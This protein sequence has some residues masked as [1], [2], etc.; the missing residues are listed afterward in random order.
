MVNFQ[1][2]EVDTLVADAG[3][4]AGMVEGRLEGRL[5]ANGKTAD[6]NALDGVGEIHLR[7]GQVRQYSLLVALGQLLQIDELSRLQFDEAQVKYHITPGV[8]T[9][10]ELVLSS[11]NIRLSAVGTISFY[12]RT[13]ARIRSSRLTTR[14]GVSSSGRCATTSSQSSRRDS[15]R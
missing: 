8:V 1:D 4:P 5:E 15:P 11:A 14:S 2:L 13:A 6:P 10:D 12:R 9:V 7:D 3:G